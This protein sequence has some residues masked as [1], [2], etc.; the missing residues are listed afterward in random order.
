V[1][2]AMRKKS[3]GRFSGEWLEREGVYNTPN[4]LGRVKGGNPDSNI[5]CKT[6]LSADEK[7]A[8]CSFSHKTL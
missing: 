6:H 8:S 3:S 7:S 5:A 4:S 1:V 2:E